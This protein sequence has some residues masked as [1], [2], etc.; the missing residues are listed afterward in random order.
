MCEAKVE[1]LGQN[2][3]VEV[4]VEAK[5]KRPR[6]NLKRPNRTLYFTV[7]IYAV[8]KHRAV[9]NA[10]SSL[11]TLH[12]TECLFFHYSIFQMPRTPASVTKCY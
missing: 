8:K 2:L 7:K 1:G 4:E 5:F 9:V 3:E 10:I 11:I 12:A 6:P